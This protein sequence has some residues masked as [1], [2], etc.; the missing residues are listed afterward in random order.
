MNK[1]PFKMSIFVSYA[2][3]PLRQLCWKSLKTNPLVRQLVKISVLQKQKNPA[4]F[5]TKHIYV[6]MYKHEYEYI[7]INFFQAERNF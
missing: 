2:G 5:N 1:S 3:I 7:H 6:W 4:G